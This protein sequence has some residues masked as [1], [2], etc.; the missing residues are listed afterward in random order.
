[1]I[2]E[3]K[4]WL[5][6]VIQAQIQWQQQQQHEMK[7]IHIFLSATY[8]YYY[9]YYRAG[10]DIN[11]CKFVLYTLVSSP[12]ASSRLPIVCAYTC[13]PF[14]VFL[15]LFTK[16]VKKW[17]MSTSKPCGQTSGPLRSKFIH[18]LC[19]K[20]TNFVSTNPCARVRLFIYFNFQ[21]SL[22]FSSS[23]SPLWLWVDATHAPYRAAEK[24]E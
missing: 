13:L 2:M 19:M 1:M 14:F 20:C 12:A 18:R 23:S 22:F 6:F 4:N 21:C 8:D 5:P 17:L 10:A 7:K 11:L 3:E 16:W 9:C 24:W 15:S